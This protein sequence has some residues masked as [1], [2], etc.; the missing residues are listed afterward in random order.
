MEAEDQEHQ[1][2]RVIV[3]EFGDSLLWRSGS[4]SMRVIV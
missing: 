4:V 2:P 1:D 3:I